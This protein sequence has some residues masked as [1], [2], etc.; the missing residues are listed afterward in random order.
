MPDIHSDGPRQ[1]PRKSRQGLRPFAEE[2]TEPNESEAGIVPADGPRQE[3][4]ELVFGLTVIL[5]RGEETS[6][7]AINTPGTS[8][9]TAPSSCGVRQPCRL[10]F[11]SSMRIDAR[12]ID[13]DEAADDRGILLGTLHALPA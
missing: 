5:P 13:H 1:G 7:L 3:A 6:N 10:N 2:S 12:W 4:S 9:P 8:V 11:A